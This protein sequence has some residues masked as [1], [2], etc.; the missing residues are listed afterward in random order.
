VT[1]DNEC[2][3]WSVGVSIDSYSSCETDSPTPA[4]QIVT[5]SPTKKPTVSFLIINWG[6]R[7]GSSLGRIY[8]VLNGEDNV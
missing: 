5:D 3:A 4:P 2:Y 1:Y 6:Y 7:N 8:F